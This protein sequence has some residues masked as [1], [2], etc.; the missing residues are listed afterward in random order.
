MLLSKITQ[1]RNQLPQSGYFPAQ[2]SN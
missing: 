2:R 1:E